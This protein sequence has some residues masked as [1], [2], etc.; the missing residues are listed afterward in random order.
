MSNRRLLAL[1]AA[2]SAMTLAG[3]LNVYNPEAEKY[4]PQWRGPHAT[5]VSKNAKPP[6]EWSET[7]NIR[8]KKEIPG[9]GSGTPVVWGDRVYVLTAV[10]R[11]TAPRL[12]GRR[13]KAPRP[14][15]GMS[16]WRSTAQ[17]RQGRLGADRA[18]GSAARGHASTVR[19]FASSSAV[20]DGE[21]RRRVVRVARHLRLR[22]GRQA[23]LAERSRRQ[24][25]AQPVRRGQ[26]AGLHGNSVV[27]VWDHQGESFIAALDKRTGNER[28]RA[29]ARG[30]RL[31]GRRRSSSSTAAGRRW[32]QPAT[33][34]VRSYDLET[35]KLVWYGDGLTVN[36]IP[37]PVATTAS[38]ILTSGFRGND[39]QAVKLA[40]AKDD[41]TKHRRI[42]WTLDRDTP[43]VPVATAVRRH[44]L[45]A[46]RRIPACS[47]PSTRRRGSRTTSC[48]D[49]TPR[50]TCLRHQSAPPDA[51]MFQARK[52]RPPC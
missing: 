35:G 6:L 50:P 9:R 48:S 24:D 27:V 20:T 3:A 42:A 34:Q 1:G 43:Y 7:K 21:H 16:S 26:H 25:D 36:P 28:W 17:D 12:H 14:L 52:G 22:H 15:T 23:A 38:C 29:E 4:W 41:I 45:S 31:A 32:S 13:G 18:R 47:R 19:T 40:D 8:W 49:S 5:G 11:S 46:Q 37:S 2:G 30:D 51:S 33:N 10:P 44:S 39:L